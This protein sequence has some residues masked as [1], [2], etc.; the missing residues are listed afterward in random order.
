[1]GCFFGFGE[2]LEHF[3]YN[4][5]RQVGFSGRVSASFPR[6]RLE[7][8]PI[9]PPESILALVESLDHQR[10]TGSGGRGVL[11]TEPI[12]CSFLH[13]LVHLPGLD[14]IASSHNSPTE[15]HGTT[16]RALW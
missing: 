10:Q 6:C 11:K 13:G 5:R 9:P 8:S 16:R 1:M 4:V 2:D 3:R 15:A 12:W 14:C 7:S